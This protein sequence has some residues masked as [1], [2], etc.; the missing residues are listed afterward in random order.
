MK[1]NERLS[2]IPRNI[3][4]GHRDIKFKGLAILEG[5][6]KN[7]LLSSLNILLIKYLISTMLY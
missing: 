6:K 3:I 2:N 5:M 7:I 1:Y 4:Y